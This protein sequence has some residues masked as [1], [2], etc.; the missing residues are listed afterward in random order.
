[1]AIAQDPGAAAAVPRAAS[2]HP[3]VAAVR[4]P[5]QVMGAAVAVPRTASRVAAVRRT[6]GRAGEGG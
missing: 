3:R 4:R 1:M 6:T 2:Q 5:V